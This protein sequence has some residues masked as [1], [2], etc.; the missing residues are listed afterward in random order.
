MRIDERIVEDINAYNFNPAQTCT[1][2]NILF[3][4]HF[5]TI[6]P[7]CFEINCLY[8]LCAR[9]TYSC[10]SYNDFLRKINGV[11]FSFAVLKALSGIGGLTGINSECS[12]GG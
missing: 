10:N 5:N 2:S 11:Q 9:R 8:I 3:D 7:G 12:L 4:I 1:W 6:H